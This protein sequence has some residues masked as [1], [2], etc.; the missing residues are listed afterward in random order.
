MATN[1][2]SIPL[3]RGLSKENPPTVKD[4]PGMNGKDAYSPLIGG[5]VNGRGLTTTKH[6]KPGA[7][8]SKDL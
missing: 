7:G 6:T 1:D 3:K 2:K 4:Y 5:V 8:R